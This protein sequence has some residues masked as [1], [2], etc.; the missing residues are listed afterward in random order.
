[1]AQRTSP[2]AEEPNRRAELVR[3]A[4]RLF[5]EQGYDATTIRDIAAAV[6]MRSGSPFY[7]F[8]SKQDL[9]KT[10]VLE[11]MHAALAAIE[12]V[13]A[14]RL[15]PRETFHALIRAHLDTI[16]VSGGDFAPVL[17]HEWRSLSPESRAEIVA[18][19]DRY[20]K[21][22]QKTLTDLKRANLIA[23]DSSLARLLIIGSINW[24]AQWYRPDGKLSIDKL[25]K[26]TANFFLLS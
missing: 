26:R 23:D 6:G 16:L 1:M 10:V 3:A 2:A 13:L 19:K 11:G 12:A 15:P 4:G 22:W 14:Q 25:A 24:T 18:S 17:L 8:K 7:H 9:L 5:R 21:I 20:E